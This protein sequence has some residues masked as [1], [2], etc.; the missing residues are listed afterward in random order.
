MAKR[1]FVAG[2]NGMVGSALVRQLSAD[3][4]NTLITRS[5]AELD[6][7]NQASVAD[8]FAREQIDEVYLAAAKVG[9]IHANDNYPAEVIYDN[10]M[11]GTQLIEQSRRTGVKKFVCVGTICAYP[12]HTPVPFREESLW[13]GYPEETNAPYGLAKKMMLV[14]LQAYR[15]QYG[16]N[17][18]YLLPVNLYGPEDNFDLDSSHVIP[19][20]IR[21]CIEARDS[22]ATEVSCW[23][24]GKATREFLYVDDCAEGIVR[25][26]EQ[27]EGT[28]PVN[29]GSG[30]EISIRDLAE[31]IRR[32]SGFE[33]KLVW[34]A[35]KPDGQPRRCLDTTRAREKFG[36]SAETTLEYGI[37]STIEW[38]KNLRRA[39]ATKREVSVG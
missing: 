19:A 24:S 2:H 28:E 30:R 8:F 22:G 12:K 27:L 21:K 34:D 15:E 39:Q 20:L 16:F 17:G 38:Y 4:G 13:D 26:A 25:A 23:G 32:Y 3:S 35:D 11:M 29:L 5:R 6:L 18:V 14:Q 7:L 36:F 33:G 1:I 37:G 31:M 9:G 10:L